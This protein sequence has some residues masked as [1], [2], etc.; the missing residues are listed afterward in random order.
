LHLCLR[1]CDVCL[2]LCLCSWPLQ[3]FGPRDRHITL[4]GL[5]LENEP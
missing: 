1:L 3:R 4:L 2:G 5:A